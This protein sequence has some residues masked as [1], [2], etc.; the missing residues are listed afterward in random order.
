[1][2]GLLTIPH[3]NAHCERIFSSIR[4]NRTD[5]RAILG[6]G[7]LE[8][9]LVVKNMSE[10]HKLSNNTLRCMKGVYYRSLQK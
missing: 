9:L 4:K 7:T 1:M 2:K 10:P 6:D 8:A 3:S 5:Q